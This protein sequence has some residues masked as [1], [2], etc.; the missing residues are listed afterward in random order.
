MQQDYLDG[1]ATFIAVAEEKG[2]SAAAI[3]LGVSPS[4]VSQA[5]RNLERRT[6]LALFNRNTRGVSLTEAGET[7]FERIGPAVRELVLASEELG[8]AAER[9]AGVLRINVARAGQM[10]VMQP[11]LRRFLDRYPDIRIDLCIDNT[12][13][14]IVGRGFDAGI[15]FGDLVERDM[16]AVKVGP[17]IAAWILAAPDYLQRRGTPAHPRELMNHECVSFRHRTSGQI[18]RW[19]F[20]KDG[21]AIDLAVNGQLIV[22]DSAALVQAA[23]DG[24]GIV[25]MINGYVERLVEQGRLVRLLADWSPPLPGFTLYYASRRRVPAKLRALIDF[26]REEWT[27]AHPEADLLTG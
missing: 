27:P 8:S 16:V 24:I 3:K 25:Y 2:F 9:P 12:L 22:N 23:L 6:G 15:R 18:E 20:S 13:V 7:Y 11:V 26:L 17:P 10:I 1:I 19:S 21:E 14:D 5:I 4:A